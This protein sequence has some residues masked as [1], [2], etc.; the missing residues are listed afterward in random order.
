MPELSLPSSILCRTCP[1]ILDLQSLRTQPRHLVAGDSDDRIP[2]HPVL[3]H[4]LKERN[5]CK[6]I[7]LCAF[8]QE[9][10]F[11]LHFCFASVADKLWHEGHFPWVSSP[12]ADLNSLE[13][14]EVAALQQFRYL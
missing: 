4:S 11:S 12:E 14:V 2:V 3:E 6:E 10:V 8:Q 1:F 9:F 5:D 13:Q 7:C